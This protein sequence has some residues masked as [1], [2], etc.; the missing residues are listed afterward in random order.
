MN[1]PG[2]PP[3]LLDISQLYIAQKVDINASEFAFGWSSI[4][5]EISKSNTN[6]EHLTAAALA[7][8]IWEICITFD[9]EVEY[10]WP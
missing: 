10:I 4:I 9:D 7:F 3:G 2:Q 5:T 1:Y 8:F 6:I